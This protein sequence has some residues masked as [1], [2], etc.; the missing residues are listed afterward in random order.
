MPITRVVL[1]HHNAALPVGPGTYSGPYFASSGY[2]SI[3]GDYET[4][5]HAR[6]LV[7]GTVWSRFP[8]PYT[9]NAAMISASEV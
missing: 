9:H 3:C 6:Y 5:A 7:S 2:I 1:F 4:A 8:A